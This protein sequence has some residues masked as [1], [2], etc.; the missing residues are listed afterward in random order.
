MRCLPVSRGPQ[1]R[2]S[3]LEALDQVV[4]QR[5]AD[6]AVIHGTEMLCL[7]PCRYR[8]RVVEALCGLRS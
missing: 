3:F 6:Y 1:I 8:V 5:N 7:W 2:R 4:Q